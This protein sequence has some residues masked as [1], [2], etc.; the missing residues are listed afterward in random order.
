MV[1]S[2]AAIILLVI[3]QL[4]GQ[5]VHGGIDQTTGQQYISSQDINL[6][7]LQQQGVRTQAKPVEENANDPNNAQPRVLTPRVQLLLPTAADKQV[8]KAAAYIAGP[9]FAQE[10]QLAQQAAQ[11]AD[12]Q[13]AAQRRA[14]TQALRQSQQYQAASQPQYVQAQYAE[15]QQYSP[16]QYA[17][18]NIDP[19]YVREPTQSIQQ[20]PQEEAEDYDPNP[21]YQFG[22]YVKDD[23]NTN[24]QNRKEQREGNTISGSYSVVDSDGFLRTVKYTAHPKEGFKAEVIRKPTDI[25][26]KVPPP[27]TDRESRQKLEQGIPNNDQGLQE[28]RQKYVYQY[29]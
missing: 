4:Y 25:V 2:C 13:A 16:S 11:A 8:Q 1:V 26:V 28:P 23:V 18:T 14:Q 10:I 21:S 12:A 29:Q 6:Q 27:Y 22:F 17:S 3:G 19:Q 24:Y 15:P 5:L 20:R 7:I 9:Q